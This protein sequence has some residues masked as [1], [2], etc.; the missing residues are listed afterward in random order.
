MVIYAPFNSI[1]LAF[2]TKWSIMASTEV[3][4]PMES[5]YPSGVNRLDKGISDFYY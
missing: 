3:E 5:V 2:A 1:L 4:S